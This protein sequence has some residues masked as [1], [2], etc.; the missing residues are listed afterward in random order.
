MGR[1]RWQHVDGESVRNFVIFLLILQNC[2]RAR[3]QRA[4][5]RD[6]LAKFEFNGTALY[7]FNFAK[8]YETLC[9]Q[10]APSAHRRLVLI[11]TKKPFHVLEQLQHDLEE[12]LKRTTTLKPFHVLEQLELDAQMLQPPKQNASFDIVEALEMDHA[13][14]L[15]Q[16]TTIKPFHVIEQLDK[17]L[18]HSLNHRTTTIRPF[19][20][21]EELHAEA[22]QESLAEHLLHAATSSEEGF[23]ILQPVEQHKGVE[24][25]EATRAKDSQK[26]KRKRIRRRRKRIRKRRKRKRKRGKKKRK[27]RK[28]RKKGDKKK[29]NKR[30]KQTH[31][32]VVGQPAQLIFANPT[33]QPYYYPHHYPAHPS[34]TAAPLTTKKPATTHAPFNKIKYIL[35]HNSLLKKKKKEYLSHVGHVV[36]PF[37]KFV[38]F[39]TV[40]NPFTLGVFLF[41]LLSPVVFGFLGFVALSVL[42]KPFLHLVFGVKRNV[43]DIERKRWRAAKRAERWRLG[44]RPIT[45]H[46]HYYEQRPLHSK[47]PTV[48]RPV[49]VS[50]WRRQ[51]HNPLLPE[52]RISL[53]NNSDNKFPFL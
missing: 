14:H 8:F 1:K 27:K 22:H 43:D 28:K 36:Y 44:Q 52:Q 2:G 25:A 7:D 50:D 46:K 9:S 18:S 20:V 24:P 15:K 21:M 11:T 53:A 17:D 26:R 41:S 45:I 33:K 32:T 37:V 29:K 38:A 35:R 4:H 16:T 3:A 13:A 30:K 42:V 34:T 19:N 51:Q 48:L 5:Q 40:L 12:K 49:V 6:G 47:P 39:F 31:S 23:E 10:L